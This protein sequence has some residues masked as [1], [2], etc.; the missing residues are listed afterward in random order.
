MSLPQGSLR[1]AEKRRRACSEHT[2][3][4]ALQFLPRGQLS[5]TPGLGDPR[6]QELR[7]SGTRRPKDSGTRGP[8][9][10]AG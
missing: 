9:D 1:K 7:D 3:R 10:P 6:T 8:R 5:E 4:R 2:D